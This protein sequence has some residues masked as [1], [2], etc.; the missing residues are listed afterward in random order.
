M[1]DDNQRT[2]RAAL[3]SHANPLHIRAI[4]EDPCAK[5]G[6]EAPHAIAGYRQ[7]NGIVQAR[8]WCEVCSRWV[9]SDLRM[10][11]EAK[12]PGVLVVVKDNT[13]HAY[14]A[15]CERCDA[16][17]PVELH[18]WAPVSLFADAWDWPM[19]ELCRECHRRWHRVTKVAVGP[20]DA[21]RDP[22]PAGVP[23]LWARS[24]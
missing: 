1:A 18:H 4:T 15:Y 7:A 21:P 10:P 14:S 13:G 16:Y 12:A 3:E 2:L 22:L 8:G 6:A 20:S 17:G 19:S 23:A 9:T 24:E 5:C 11:A